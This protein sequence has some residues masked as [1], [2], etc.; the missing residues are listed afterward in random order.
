CGSGLIDL[1]AQMRKAAI[2]DRTGMFNSL[3]N[4]RISVVD[5]EPRY[6]LAFGFESGNGKD[7]YITE[8]DV[9]NLIRSKGAV[10]AGI[11]SMLKMVELTV[12]AI[13]SIIIAGGFGNY[14]N[15]E[16]AIQIGLLPDM[17]REKYHFV[18]N[19]SIKGAH[20]SLLS[21]EAY[22]FMSELSDKMTYIELSVGNVFMDE[23]SA[24]LFLPHTDLSLFPSV[25][26]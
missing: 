17:D 26:D 21:Q 4:K 22:R 13:D 18:G 20:E 3:E 2:I 6:V 16:D 25:G 1:I 7:V 9:K 15:V 5:N 19:S 12:D 14:L 8:S 11:K 23:Y 10:Y 24:A